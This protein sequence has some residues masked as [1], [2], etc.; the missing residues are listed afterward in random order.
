MPAFASASDAVPRA[1][2]DPQP[3]TVYRTRQA[4]RTEHQAHKQLHIF[5]ACTA[6]CIARLLGKGWTKPRNVPVGGIRTRNR[7]YLARVWTVPACRT[8]SRVCWRLWPRSTPRA[9]AARHVPSRDCRSCA[10]RTRRR[11]SAVLWVSVGA[12]QSGGRC[13]I[14]PT[15]N[16]RRSPCVV[17]LPPSPLIYTRKLPHFCA[18]SQKA[19][20][21]LLAWGCLTP[22][23]ATAAGLYGLLACTPAFDRSLRPLCCHPAGHGEC[24]A[25]KEYCQRIVDRIVAAH[26]KKWRQE[27]QRREQEQAQEQEHKQEQEQGQGQGQERRA[28]AGEAP[29]LPR[30]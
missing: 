8:E 4:S 2:N 5:C 15:G 19:Y 12:G 9:S 29:Q 1:H 20:P 16:A 25:S 11:V 28:T 18:P 30:V 23:P 17:G 3:M 7:Y 27:E 13:F 24:E 14:R 6:A 26:V 10:R 22:A 21:C